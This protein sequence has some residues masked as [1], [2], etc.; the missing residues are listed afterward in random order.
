MMGI[1]RQLVELLS[2]IGFIKSG[3]K[4]RD[5]ERLQNPDNDGVALAIGEDT[6][7]SLESQLPMIKGCLVASLWP[8]GNE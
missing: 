3:I 4:I 7:R 1:R 8:N 5:I 2:D 6:K